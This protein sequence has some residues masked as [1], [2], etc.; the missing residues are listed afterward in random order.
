[1]QASIP[2]HNLSVAVI[3]SETWGQFQNNLLASTL[4]NNE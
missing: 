2:S 4:K 1:M 3:F